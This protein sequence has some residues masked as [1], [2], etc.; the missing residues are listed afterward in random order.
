MS[1]SRRYSASKAEHAFISICVTDVLA[2]DMG[3]MD[4]EN[5]DFDGEEEDEGMGADASATPPDDASLVFKQ[6]TGEAEKSGLVN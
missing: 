1:W 6:H 3:D 2:D 5:V 4:L